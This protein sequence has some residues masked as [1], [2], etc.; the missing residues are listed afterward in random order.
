MGGWVIRL[1]KKPAWGR[2]FPPLEPPAFSI[3]FYVNKQYSRAIYTFLLE[4]HGPRAPEYC[5]TVCKVRAYCFTKN[6][7]SLLHCRYSTEFSLQLSP[8]TVLSARIGYVFCGT[9]IVQIELSLCLGGQSTKAYSNRHACLSVC[10]CVCVCVCVFVCVC[11]HL[12]RS[13]RTT[14]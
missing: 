1:C 12:E 4:Q 10:V 8:L 5:I 13:L 2:K 6:Y 9:L 11:F 3:V 7:F 14:R